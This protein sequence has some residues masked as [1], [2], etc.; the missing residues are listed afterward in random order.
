MELNTFDN[1]FYSEMLQGQRGWAPQLLP[2]PVSLHQ[3]CAAAYCS[4]NAH[5]EKELAFGLVSHRNVQVLVMHGGASCRHLLPPF[6][7]SRF[8]YQL[9]V[10][11][12]TF[13]AHASTNASTCCL[14]KRIG[15]GTW[16]KITTLRQFDASYRRSWIACFFKVWLFWI[17]Q[18]CCRIPCV[19]RT[20]H[21]IHA[22]HMYR[23]V[24]ALRRAILA[25]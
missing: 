16:F 2:P 8:R 4:M 11:R 6:E 9:P 19:C 3:W 1:A 23:P 15:L 17:C 12:L 5:A 18:V 13:R 20:P 24:L 10:P 21:T 22:E 7:T 14:V 25:L